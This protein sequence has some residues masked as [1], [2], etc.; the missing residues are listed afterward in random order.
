MNDTSINNTIESIPKQNPIMSVLN[1]VFNKSIIQKEEIDMQLVEGKILSYNKAYKTIVDVQTTTSSHS[2]SSWNNDYYSYKGD[3]SLSTYV[4]TNV[5]ADNIPV[6]DFWLGFENGSESSYTITKEIPMRPGH[7]L[8]LNYLT[9]D[10]DNFY[11]YEVDNLS[12]NSS[13]QLI[14]DADL[15]G[16]IKGITSKVFPISI[17]LLVGLI[18]FFIKFLMMAAILGYG[19]YYIANKFMMKRNVNILREQLFYLKKSRV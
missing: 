4:S 12:T 18:F 15:E 7:E 2:S 10:G 14:S 1:K 11:L 5:K 3:V 9:V 17:G 6:I 19:A 16:F 8:R 13:D